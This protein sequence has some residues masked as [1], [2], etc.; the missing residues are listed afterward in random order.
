MLD[1]VVVALKRSFHETEEARAVRAKRRYEDLVKGRDRFQDFQVAW[2][3]ALADEAGN[4]K[5]RILQDT[6]FWAVNP[7]PGETAVFRRAKSWKE[8]AVA[9]RA[10][11]DQTYLAEQAGKGFP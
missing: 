3:E 11:Q 8:A 9:S 5:E 10:L 7:G 4:L 2:H 6:R 1:R